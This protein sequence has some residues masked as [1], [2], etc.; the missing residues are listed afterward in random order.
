MSV[1]LSKLRAGDCVTVKLDH[2]LAK[3]LREVYK[4]HI[5][6]TCQII[7]VTPAA[8][9]CEHRK[10]GSII[11]TTDFV[12]CDRC[13]QEIKPKPTP[14]LLD[15]AEAFKDLV[16]GG[17]GRSIHDIIKLKNSIHSLIKYLK[18]RE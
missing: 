2:Q 6:K 17:D 8:P 5:I 12:H 13:G 4:T 10:P 7:S 9:V 14:S 1:D 16:T 18:G 15:E 3:E 11:P